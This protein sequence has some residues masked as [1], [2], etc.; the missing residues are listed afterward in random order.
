MAILIIAALYFG[1]LE[2]SKYKHKKELREYK[3]LSR[4][5]DAS[6]SSSKRT[7]NFSDDEIKIAAQK[8]IL[9][10]LKAPSTA[11]FPSLNSAKIQKKNNRTYIVTLYVDSQNEFGA[12]IRSYWDVKLKQI[13][14]DNIRLVNI[15]H[16]K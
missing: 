5:L 15:T 11:K 10:H 14:N 7:T 13:K 16:L 4:K 1:H 12:I 3:E 9:P 6:Y 8:Y 2:Y